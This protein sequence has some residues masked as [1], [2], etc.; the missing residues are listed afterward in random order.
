MKH[1]HKRKFIF[2]IKL[3]P[4][5]FVFILL[6]SFIESPFIV[7]SANADC[8][9][10][11]HDYT[12][13]T[14]AATENKD[15][16]K[17]YTCK[18][19]G[20]SFTRILTATG[21]IWGEWI[22]DK[23]P[24]CTEA[25]HKYR[26]CTKHDNDPHREEETIPELGHS[27]EEAITLPTCGEEGW[28][29]YTCQRCGESYMEPHGGALGHEYIESVTK[30]PDCQH[31]GEKTYICS[32]CQYS[33]TEPFG[34]ALGHEYIESVTKEPDCQQDGEKT[35]TCERDG[36]T[37]TKAI[38]ALGHSFGEWIT[39]Q[40]A[41][42]EEEGHRYRVCEHDSSHIEEERIPRL[43]ASI[44]EDI[45]ETIEEPNPAFPNRMDMIIFLVIPIMDIGFCISIC[46][47]MYIVH[48]DK[49]KRM[50]FKEWWE[51]QN[52]GDGFQ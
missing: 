45:D 38:P 43:T 18:D 36:Q 6:W 24:T 23:Q 29:T 1:L 49:K 39:D 15:G 32:R 34:E 14:E 41:T 12:I 26:I 35:Y 3:F 20:Y 27:Y 44:A 21:H 30:E 52:K 51:K 9:A 22:T 48:W 31:Q 17:T 4:V 25:G 10:G 46:S 37:Y 13:T 28:K 19:C 40:E 42:E 47:D 2:G 7:S 8:A 16:K 50:P 11:K 33:Y 5:F